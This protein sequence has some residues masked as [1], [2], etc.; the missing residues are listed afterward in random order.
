MGRTAGVCV[1]WVGGGGG[2]EGVEGSLKVKKFILLYADQTACN[3]QEALSVHHFGGYCM[4]RDALLRFICILYSNLCSV[5]LLVLTSMDIVCFVM[6]YS[7]SSVLLYSNLCSVELLVLTSMEFV[8]FVMLY[9]IS[10]IYY[11]LTFVLLNCLSFF[12]G[13]E[14]Q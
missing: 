7:V 6:L 1:C 12:F 9:S 2:V 4:F 8:C 14:F 5:E 10:S 11:T 3:D 13:G